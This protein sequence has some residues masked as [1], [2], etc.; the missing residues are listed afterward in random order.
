VKK[1]EELSAPVPIK[2]EPIKE[3][4][5]PLYKVDLSNLLKDEELMRIGQISEVK[6]QRR[7]RTALRIRG[8]DRN[9][10]PSPLQS[11]GGVE[12]MI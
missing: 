9:G 2:V 12:S 4:E 7:I 3:P 6:L 10:L 5:E 8:S 1:K 11:Q